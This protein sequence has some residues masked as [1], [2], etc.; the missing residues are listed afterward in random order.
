[1]QLQKQI[2]KQSKQQ[3]K[4]E[5]GAD[6]TGH[7]R[8]TVMLRN[9]PN[10]YTR[11]MLMELLDSA[12][13]GGRYDFLYL[14]CDFK[15]NSGLGFAF[16]NLVTPEVAEHLRVKLTGFKNWAIPSAKVCEVG[17]S[18]ADQQGLDANLE[19][20]RNSSV[21]HASVPEESKPLR[22][23]KGVPVSF[24]TPTRKIWPPHESYGV[25]A[26]KQG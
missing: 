4:Q 24:P 13:F 2:Q 17:W 14:P 11:Q 1:V 22:L 18:S 25:R 7:S 16:V 3:L 21:M 10:N 19:R 6:K 8:T 9:V 15:T 12:G 5:P 23:S 26:R 20:Y